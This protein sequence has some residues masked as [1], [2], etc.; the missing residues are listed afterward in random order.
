MKILLDM[1]LN[2]NL[3]DDLFLKIISERYDNCSFVIQPLCNY[4]KNELPKNVESIRNII[5]RFLNV[6][7][8]HFH[9]SFVTNY[10]KK[11]CDYYITLGGSMFIENNNK[12]IDSSLYNKYFKINKPY[13]II[14]SNFGPY[15]TNKYYTSYHKVFKD[16][17]DVCF[18]ETYSKKL[19][20]DLKNVRSASD[21]VFSLDTS[22]YKK[23]NEKKVTISIID[24]ENREELKGYSI[25]YKNK[26]ISIIEYFQSKKYSINLMSFCKSEGDEKAINDIYLNCINKSNINIINYNG[27]IDE[28]LN[29]LSTS[30]YIIATRFHA[31]ILGFLFNKKVLPIIYSEKTKNVLEDCNYKGT[32]IDIKKIDSNTT[33]NE[34]KQIGRISNIDMI[35]DKSEEQFKILDQYLK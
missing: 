1:Y 17:K 10:L 8:N 28:A 15:K 11:K 23:T 13:F 26:I 25:S 27:N 2:K 14:G 5:T 7:G 24:L 12:N 35:R 22:N 20:S 6:L 4:K 30:E 3:G 32:I 29:I 31:M 33:E 19:F 18:R 9:K 34:I 16:A 21:L